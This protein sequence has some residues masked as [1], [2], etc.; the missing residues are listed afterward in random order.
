M[1]QASS[2]TSP[3]VHAGQMHWSVEMSAVPAP[4][5]SRSAS[6]PP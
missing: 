6:R 5:R 2:L 3:L 4:W 1:V